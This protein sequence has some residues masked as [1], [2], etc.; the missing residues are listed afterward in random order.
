[1]PPS[2]RESTPQLALRRRAPRREFLDRLGQLDRRGP[3]SKREPFELVLLPGDALDG[4]EGHVRYTAGESYAFIDNQS[5]RLLA[6]PL[7]H[8]DEL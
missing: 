5:S 6:V 8:E 4:L 2:L 3:A 7:S 1:M